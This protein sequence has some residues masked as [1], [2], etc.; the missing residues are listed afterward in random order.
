MTSEYVQ[1]DALA[2]SDRYKCA[3][4]PLRSDLPHRTSIIHRAR[5]AHDDLSVVQTAF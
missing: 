1:A 3:A 5:E 2:S 4:G